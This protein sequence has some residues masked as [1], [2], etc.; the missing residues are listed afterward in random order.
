MQPEWSRRET[1]LPMIIE[2][3]EDHPEWRLSLQTHKYIGMP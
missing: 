2:F 3:L 1:A